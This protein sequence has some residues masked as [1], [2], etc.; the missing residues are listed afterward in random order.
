MKSIGQ[1]E[2]CARNSS[3]GQKY[4]GLLGAQGQ[5]QVRA[6][7][8]ITQPRKVRKAKTAK[9][10]RRIRGAREECCCLCADAG[11]KLYEGIHAFFFF[12]SPGLANGSAWFK[13]SC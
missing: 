2:S 4:R 8:R 11:L 1:V 12:L 9:E 6:W 3:E 7:K 5:W 13:W 10:E